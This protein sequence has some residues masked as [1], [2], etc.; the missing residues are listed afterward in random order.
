MVCAQLLT[1]VTSNKGVG[2]VPH[3]REDFEIGR[4]SATIKHNL[5]SNHI[6]GPL[7]GSTHWSVIVYARLSH[8]LSFQAERLFSGHLPTSAFST[9]LSD[10]RRLANLG[11]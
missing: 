2:S 10:S 8:D 3:K 1:S 7:S 9:P 6:W 4:P 5:V 11:E